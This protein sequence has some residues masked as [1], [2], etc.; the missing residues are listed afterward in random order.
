M[1]SW[2][3]L[4]RLEYFLY[5]LYFFIPA[6]IFIYGVND[7][8][9]RETDRR[10]PKKDEKEQRVTKKNEETLLRLL[11]VVFGLSLVLLIFQ[12]D[13]AERLIFSSFLLLSYFYSA[14]P[15]RFKAIPI[16]DFMSN[17]LYVVP[18][19]FGYYLAANHLP[20]FLYLIAGFT[21]IAAMHLFSA[22]PDIKYDKEAN[23]TTTAVILKKTASLI[24]CFIFWSILA[25]LVIYLA[26]FHPLSFLVF[27]YP[28]IPGTLL[29]KKNLSIEKVYWT[30]PLINTSLGGLLF[31]IIVLSAI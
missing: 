27:I 16:V 13:M 8:W 19:I 23:I 25:I 2:L 24:V 31:V 18:G 17:M 30:L 28:A 10:N 29:V 12:S 7:Y 21:H 9:D 15:F 20:P 22:I 6:N 4:L 14:E 26:G 5:L 1:N 11:Y 3:D